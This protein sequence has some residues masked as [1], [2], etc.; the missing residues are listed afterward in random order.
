[1]DSMMDDT[2]LSNYS[3]AERLAEVS[4]LLGRGLLRLER[5]K[6]S[7]FPDEPGES[8]L[9]F[10]PDQSGHAAPVSPEVSP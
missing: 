7:R 1:M 3:P 8:S 6:S 10:S 9:H 5:G 2:T 4:D